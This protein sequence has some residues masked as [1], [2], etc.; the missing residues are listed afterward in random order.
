V[1]N[2]LPLHINQNLLDQ[3]LSALREA[4]GDDLLAVVLYG[5][6][7]KGEAH[8]QSDWDLLLIAENLPEKPLARHFFLKRALPAACRGTI[9]LLA[10]FPAEFEARVPPLYLDIAL[11][12]EI[13]YDSRGY[14]ATR[15][16]KLKN[17]I[18]MSGL[19]RLRSKDGEMWKFTI[20]P[21]NPWCLSWE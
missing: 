6:R 19:H 18:A 17:L 12:G 13:L 2:N 5:S 14:A 15:L 21:S 16:E 10:K 9:S 4:L 1:N 3:A 7:A 11:D 20:P 8:D